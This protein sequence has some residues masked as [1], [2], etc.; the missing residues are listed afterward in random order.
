[1]R[2]KLSSEDAPHLQED[3]RRREFRAAQVRLLYSSVDVGVIAMLI[4][5]TVLAWLQWPVISHRTILIWWS[6]TFSVALARFT[7]G[8]GYWHTIR[9]TTPAEWWG[10]A[11][12]IVVGLAGAGW[13]AAGLWLYPKD[14]L[15]NQVFLVFILGGMMLGAAS[16]LAARIEAFVAFMLPTGVAPTLSLLLQGDDAHIA[17]GAMAG[18]FVVA[19]LITT[20]RV[21][22]TIISGLSLRFENQDLVEHLQAAKDQTEKLNE[23]LEERIRERTAE[24]QKSAEQLM[25]E[26]KHREQIEE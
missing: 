16:L 25:A 9:S 21:H 3:F 19:T 15:E 4:G 20:W 7:L 8:R 23:K 17:M 5:T 13:G 11:Y 6:Y 1:M 10:W 24:L 26:M 18:V 14:H 22:L 12:S 2:G